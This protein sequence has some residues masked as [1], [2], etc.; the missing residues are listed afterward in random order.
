MFVLVFKDTYVAYL[1]IGFLVMASSLS[2]SL[3]I[4]GEVLLVAFIVIFF[5]AL[6][7]RKQ[8]VLLKK[9]MEKCNQMK[10]GYEEREREYESFYGASKEGG[11]KQSLPDYFAFNIND[12]QQRYEKYT[13]AKIP[14]IEVTEPFSAKV[15]ALRYLYLI[16]EKEVFDARG[17]TQAGWIMFEKK[18]ADIVHWFTKQTTNRQDVR[19][20]R[21][22]LLQE[23][24]DALKPFETENKKLQR[25]LDHA[26]KRQEQLE[27]YQR[28][29]KA[30]I[31]S[32]QKMLNSIKQSN[33]DGSE[34]GKDVSINKMSP[35]EYLAYSS[36]Q[37]DSIANA[38]DEKG[39]VLKNI[40]F[41]LNN[42]QASISP[43]VKKKMESSIRMMEIEMM[44][45]DLYI[46]NLKKELKDAKSQATN[47]AL[48]LNESKGAMRKEGGAQ[49]DNTLYVSA[50][51]NQALRE[52]TPLSLTDYMDH[53]KI[54]LEIKQL[55]ENNKSQ[56]AIIVNLE[57]DISLLKDSILTTEDEEVRKAKQQE[58]SRLERVVKECEGCIEI[59]ESEVDH[60]YTQLQ[61]R[62]VTSDGA[63]ANGTEVNEDT[64]I[65]KL[66]ME[67]EEMAKEMEKIAFQYR[68]THAINQLIYDIVKCASV[69]E[70]AT[71]IIQ[72][73]KGFN[74]PAGFC[75][76]SNAG[77]AEYLPS[78]VFNENA[79][80]LVKSFSFK[81]PVFYVNEGTLFSSKKLCLMLLP[82]ADKTKPL[83]ETNLLGLV[84]VVDEHIQQLEAEGALAQRSQG[85]SSWI[86]STKNHLADLDIQYAYQVEENR[87]TFNNF[88]AEIRQAYHL[89]DLK[90]SGLILLDNAINEYEQRMYLLLSSGDIIDREISTLIT[91]IDQLKI[92]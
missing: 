70:V 28:E 75:I 65:V 80:E 58:L 16:A 11:N 48:M 64:D 19:N 77:N 30:T 42:N 73:F 88:I 22:R 17:L 82:V 81:D 2:L 60:L 66:G 1:E 39:R 5:M 41:E 12:A 79:K 8:K 36:K 3:L 49:G 92:Q 83:S 56:R 38:S 35:E 32:L 59:L 25:S 24:I 55:R 44:K 71:L 27:G 74:A 6:Y 18:L 62:G 31:L 34:A 45:S 15:A 67:L 40:I 52:I 51:D 37:V 13:Q 54:V 61:E 23:R 91:H 84:N 90:G 72:F 29:N 85:M 14:K 50:G 53:G 46:S 87:K 78:H 20:N 33:S 26:K 7:I 68:Q 4:M 63:V 69:E 57:H 89:L 9:L 47:Y 21:T 76:N 86:E 10:S 43:E